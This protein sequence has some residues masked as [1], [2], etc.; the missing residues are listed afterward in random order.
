MELDSRYDPKLFEAATYQAWLDAGC[1]TPAKEPRPGQKPFV[2]MIPPPNVTGVLHMGHALNGTLQDIVIRFRR[3]QGYDA[4]WLPGTDHA[5][6]ATQAV[7]E[8]KL[9]A[10]RGLTRNDLGRDAFLKEVW[11]WKEKHGNL[12]LEQYR[13]LG[14]SCDWSRT[15]F[16]MDEDL[17]RAVREAFLRLWEKGLVYRGARL[18]HWDCV[19]ETAISDDEIE[20]EERKGKLWYLRYPLEGRPGEFLTVATTRPE[21][22]LG[23]TGVAVHPEDERYRHLVGSRVLL[24][25]LDRPIPIVADTTV[26]PSYGTGAV[27][28][29]PGHD[30]ADYERGKRH[31]LPILIVIEKDGRMAP[32]AGPFAGLSREKARDAVVKGMDELGLLDKV[33]D[34]KHSVALSDRSKSVIEPLVSEQWFVA[35]KELAGPAIRAVDN[36]SLS[37]RPERWTKVYLDWLHNVQDWC[38]SRQLWWGHRIPIW[39]DEDGVPA[40]SRQDLEIGAPHPVTGK[41]IVRQDPDVLDTWASSWLWPF[42]TL[43]WPDDTADLKRFYPTQFLSTAR[44][45]IYLWV[46]RMI[47]AGYEFVDTIPLEERCAFSV[48]YVHATVLDGKGKRMSKSAGN[49]I[50]PIDMIEQYGA[51]A[52]RHSLMMLTREGQDVR[53]SENRFEEGRR[54]TNKIWNAARFVLQRMGPADGQRKFALDG[55]ELELED[56]WI[57]SR[58]ET[59]RVEAT[60]ALEAYRFNDA[61]TGLYRFVWNDFCDW[62]LELVK[63]RLDESAPAASSAAARG[64]L[65]RVLRDSLALLHPVIPFLSEVLF[66]KLHGV[67]GLRREAF[68]AASPWPTGEGL[69]RDA[70]AELEIGLL[71]DVVRALRNLRALTQVSDRAPLDALL[72]A[73]GEA[74]RRV[75]RELSPRLVEL[76]RLASLRVEASAARPPHSAAEVSGSVEVFLVLEAGTDTAKLLETLDRRAQKARAALAAIEGKLKNPGFRSNADPELIAAEEARAEEHRVELALLERNLAGL[77]G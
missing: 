39:Y 35:M 25:F 13:R 73:P 65:A 54:F 71:Q 8:K 52:V 49:G 68:L 72:V 26:D 6:I 44:E 14:A 1:F 57:L 63:G 56:R 50:D 31:N 77:H 32:N 11:D 55:L 7:V 61:A 27:K 75:L 12:I 62:Y 2:I 10:E 58:L 4:L 18:V 42:A 24:P 9:F 46:A 69:K 5:G 17:S 67:L 16:T 34:I 66:D 30:P 60:E 53:L 22:M 59:V 29:T 48:C 45:I 40:G 21:T 41:P 70:A 36:G 3:M 15:K 47:M 37:L 51:D 38:I 20:Y 64:T 43:G 19:L 23:D 28:L 33:E 76:G 74:E